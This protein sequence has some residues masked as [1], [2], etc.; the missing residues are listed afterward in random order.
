FAEH[1]MGWGHPERPERYRVLSRMFDLSF[2]AN[3][4][5]LPVDSRDATNEE[6]ARVHSVS[7]VERMLAL[8]GK[9]A[10]IDADTQTSPRSIDAAVR[11]AGSGIAL[12]EAL[13]A[14][15]FTRGFAL[16]RPPGH[17]AEPERAMGFCFFSNI[18]IA[19]EAALTD[20]RVERVA[21]VDWDVHHGNGTQA[22]FYGRSDVLFCSLH[23]WPLYPGSGTE[24]EIGRGDGKG[25]TINVPLDQ[26]A[27]D[28]EL[29][30]SL[31]DL[32]LPAVRAFRP[33][34]LLV[35]A[36]YDGHRQDPLAGLSYSEAGFHAAT[37]RLCAVADELCNGRIA[38]F[39]EGGYDLEAL[40]SSVKAT[41]E[42]L[43]DRGS[44]E[45]VDTATASTQT[46]ALLQRIQVRL[47][48]SGQP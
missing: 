38:L 13:L 17:H 19:A 11:A 18:A 26:G 42:A 21:I 28:A 46:V 27:G 33:D 32:L 12:V 25:Y 31:D 23:Q 20:P 2:A 35:S 45:A 14:G 9:S 39:L 5:W 7:Y 6:L 44:Y 8:R 37:R 24:G 16:L 15:A 30:R 4:D 41:I 43:L 29:L 10:T 36:G 48:P 40:Q 3:L 1:D 22:A 34:L 47:D